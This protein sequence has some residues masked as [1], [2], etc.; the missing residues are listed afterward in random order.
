[1]ED[2]D[3]CEDLACGEDGTCQA[4][5]GPPAELAFVGAA[6]CQPCHPNEHEQWSQTLHADALASL[7][8]SDHAMDSCTACHVVGYGEGGFVSREDTPELANVQCENCHGS[9]KEHVANVG[10]ASKRPTV[11]ISSDVCGQCHTGSHHPNFDQW[12]ESGHA[13]IDEGVAEDLLV[14][15]F[16]VLTCG[17]CHSGD[18]NYEAVIKGEEVADDRFAGLTEEDL[19]PITCVVCHDPHARTGNAVNPTEGRDYQLHYAQVTSPTASNTEAGV[20]DVTRFN[21]CGQ[22]HHSRG[23]TWQATS[24]A[25][26]HSVQS[27]VYLGEM[28][29][30]EGTEPLVPNTAS[31][32]AGVPAQC[33]TCHMYRKD[34]ES[35]EAPTISGHLFTVNTEGCT[36]CHTPE[37]AQDLIDAIEAEVQAALDDIEARL[38]DPAEWQYSATGGPPEAEDAEGDEL[39]QDDISDEIKQVR[40]LYSYIISDGSLGTHNPAY[41]RAMLAEADSLLTDLGR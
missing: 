17:I 4:G 7:E 25:P 39:T 38:G 19:N 23:R 33:S 11:N 28:G 18:V 24:R 20:Q 32:H 6:T 10:D 22:C 8:A 30:P 31:V 14:G 9:A 1:M 12:Q 41:I 5:G 2:D 15:G 35:E 16:Y 40:F 37:A 3:C 36:P 13:A 34:F 27:N 21:L 26:H 29:A